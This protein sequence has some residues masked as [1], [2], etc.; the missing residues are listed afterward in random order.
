[1]IAERPRHSTPCLARPA[2]PAYIIYTSGSTGRPKGVLISHHNALA[3]LAWAQRAFSSA[4]LA[5]VMAA[6]SLCF[7]LSIFELFVPLSFGGTVI[8]AD[9]ALALAQLEAR[10]AITLLN[11]VPSALAE[12]LRAQALPQTL[13]TVNLAGEALPQALVAQLHTQLPH[14][15]ICNLYGPSEDTTYSTWAEL[16]RDETRQPPIGRPISNT[17]A[18]VLDYHGQPTPIGVIGELYLGGAGLARGYLGRP[19]LTAERFVPNPFL[20]IED[21]GLKI[22]DSQADAPEILSSILYPLSSIGSRLYRTGDLARWRQDGQLEFVGRIDHQVKLRG[23]RIELGEVESMLRQHPAV[24]EALAVVWEERPGD[25]RLVAYLVPTNDQRPTTNDQRPTTDD[26]QQGDQETRRQGDKDREQSTIYNLQSAI[27]ESNGRRTTDNGQLAGE[28]RDFLRAKLPEPMIP[29]AFVL[30]DALPLTANGKVNRKAL[31][32]PTWPDGRHAGNSGGARDTLEQQLVQIMEETL[33][34]RPISVTSNF[35]DL[36]G[37]S[38][39]AVRFLAQIEQVFGKKLPLMTLFQAPTVEQLANVLRQQATTQSSSPLVALRATGSKRPLFLVHSATG[40]LLNY[41]ELVRMLDPDLPV[42]GF[43]SVGLDGH[44][45]P[46]TQVEEMA[47]H[48]LEA[49]RSVQPEGP[50][51]IGGWSFGGTVAFE[52][53]RQL[54]TQGQE[55]EHLILIDT[56]AP[57]VPT[58]DRA[59]AR[60]PFVVDAD[61]GL[62]LIDLANSIREVRGVDLGL[63]YDQLRRLEHHAQFDLF[64]ERLRKYDLLPPNAGLSDLEGWV[65]VSQANIQAMVNYVP[66]RYT[67]P[68]ILFRS[69]ESVPDD[70]E[71]SPLPKAYIESLDANMRDPLFGWDNL[72][73]A[74]IDLYTIPGNHATMLLEPHVQ[75]FA[76]RLAHRLGQE[77]RSC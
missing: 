48:Y 11:T 58:P 25:K 32:A 28:L 21:R 64:L 71:I 20:K 43:Q 34:V 38:L 6:T 23:F 12:L 61:D 74:P 46:L 56:V 29:A 44:L 13:R 31:P 75:A 47:A 5:G 70:D 19:E 4:E 18:Y 51:T 1:V 33:H 37:Y 26:H 57:P 62:W 54:R 50:Y 24:R 49:L 40:V 77:I 60:A 15:R 73:D 52:M 63:T 39:L 67:G 66:H 16:A 14:V 65:R 30:L 68:I 76:E 36:G 10:A 72:T 69:S 3:L 2:N 9:N 27:S 17:T 53:A 41:I 55:V 45:P 59:L 22:E 42:Y 8:L 35:F 7:D